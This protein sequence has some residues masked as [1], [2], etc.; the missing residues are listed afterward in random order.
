MNLF[1]SYSHSDKEFVMRLFETLRTNGVEPFLDEKDIKVGQNILKRIEEGIQDSVGVVYI[2]SENSVKSRWVE[3]E[4]SL[5]QQRSLEDKR[6]VIYP[7]LLDD[8]ELPLSIRKLK[9][10]DFKNWKIEEKYYSTI[11]ILLDSIGVKRTIV[12]SDL[13]MF[14]VKNIEILAAAASVAKALHALSEGIYDTSF[15][16]ESAYEGQNVSIAA[17]RIRK[18]SSHFGLDP[19]SYF[20]VLKEKLS[21]LDSDG[22]KTIIS[23][24]ERATNLFEKSR[25]FKHPDHLMDLYGSFRSLARSLEDILQE[26]LKQMSPS[27]K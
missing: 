17:K 26:A 24:I 16:I 18:A 5:A 23:E 8:V 14:A 9:Y 19:S 10:L 1:I 15:A 20:A 7:I 2:I 21:S 13:L 22:A 12:G 6:F 25:F 11:G 4:I 3:E 27:F